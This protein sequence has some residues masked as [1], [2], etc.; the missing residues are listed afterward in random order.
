MEERPINVKPNVPRRRAQVI[1]LI[2]AVIL[3]VFGLTA[4]RKSL[5]GLGLMAYYLACMALLLTAVLLAV[6]DMRDI[7]RQ[8]REENSRLAEQAFDDVSAEVKQ[9]RQKRR[10]N[11]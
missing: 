2:A 5:S 11:S 6:R 10:A 4:F 1:L 3:I 9:A 8:N 7:R